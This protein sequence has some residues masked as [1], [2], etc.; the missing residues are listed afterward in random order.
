MT[1]CSK[2]RSF[3]RSRTGNLA[4]GAAMLLCAATAHAQASAIPSAQAG[5]EAQSATADLGRGT[6]LLGEMVKALGG[7]AWLN[8]QDWIYYGQAATFYKGLPHQGA[9]QFEEYYRAAPYAERVI[10][11]SH[12]GVFIETDHKD[13]AEVWN[14]DNGYEVTYKGTKPLPAKDVEDYERRRRHSLE[15]IVSDWLKQPGVIVTYGGSDMVER[16][17]AEQVD[18]LT[19]SN[20]AVTLQLDQ[21]TH[22]PLS[23]TFQW[24]DPIYKDLNTDVEEF[25]GYH[26]IQGINTPYSIVR[27]HNGDMTSQ[28]F[29]TKAVYN[30]KLP[31]DLFDPARP[32][33]KKAK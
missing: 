22:L 14:D 31:A 26:V 6:K 21:N 23:L 25:D 15:V 10:L 16:R 32:L 19:T 24:R 2:V 20:D 13:I 1:T 3:V 33:Q 9:P 17:L 29:L 27:L 8:R 18:I 11:V 7:D 30:S 12:Y 28:R 4:M 5:P